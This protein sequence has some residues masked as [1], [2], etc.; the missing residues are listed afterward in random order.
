MLADSLLTSSIMTKSTWLT[1]AAAPVLLTSL[2]LR[3]MS[4][5]REEWTVCP[6]RS[7]AAERELVRGVNTAHA[8]G[9]KF[10]RPDHGDD[11]PSD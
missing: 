8:T 11:L 1:S 2:Y 7:P 3:W 5:F 10:L 4:N 6:L 9:P